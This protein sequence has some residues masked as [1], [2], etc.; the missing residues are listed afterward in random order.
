MSEEPCLTDGQ[1][2][3]ALSAAVH[4]IGN[5]TRTDHRGVQRRNNA[6]GQSHGKTLNRPGTEGKQHDAGDQS[7]QLAV[8]DSR[9]RPIITTMDRRLRRVAGIQLLPYSLE[10]QYVGIYGHTQCQ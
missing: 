10:Y 9:Q 3:D 7:C 5:R 1:A 8:S 6:D 2:T 4:E